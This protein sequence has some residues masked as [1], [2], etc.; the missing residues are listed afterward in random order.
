MGEFTKNAGIYKL[1]CD[2]NDKIYIG[3]SINIRNRLRSHKNCKGKCYFE[4]AILKHGWD[5]FTV[6]I[7][8]IFENF[9]KS[10]NEHKML[11]VDRE[12]YY[13]KLFD[14]TNNDI[15]YN[16]CNR[17]TDRTGIPH[18]T[19][20]KEKMRQSQLGNSNHLGKLHSE[21]SKE[22]MRQAKLGVKK[23]PHSRETKEKMRQ[24]KLGKPKTI[25]HIENIRQSKIG[26]PSNRKGVKLSEETKEKMRQSQLKRRLK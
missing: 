23:N 26:K 1:T 20:T 3:K 11:I 6:E 14:S 19:E 12:E 25:E 24:A 17:S 18:S 16:I 7:L 8:E 5:S 10:N 21:E 2:K 15:G 9:D 22:K 4:N 13:I